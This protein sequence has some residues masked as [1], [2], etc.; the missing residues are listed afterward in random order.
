MRKTTIASVL[1]CCG[2]LAL[3]ACSSNFSSS[4]EAAQGSGKGQKLTV[5]I[6]FVRHR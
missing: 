4:K 6:G 5:M 2:V 3:S 1:A